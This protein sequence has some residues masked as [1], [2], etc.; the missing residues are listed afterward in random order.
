MA[1]RPERSP[2]AEL[3]DGAHHAPAGPFGPF[4]LDEYPKLVALVTAL[5]GDRGLAEDVAQEAMLRAYRRWATV[6]GYERPGAWVRRV[7][8]NLASSARRRRRAER[9]A[10]A[11]LAARPQIVVPE[12]SAES[13]ELW[14]QVRTL[15]RRQATAVTLYY[16]ADASV[17]DVAAAMG[18][19]EGTAKAHLHQARAALAVRVGDPE[20]EEIR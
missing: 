5:T 12:L 4:F 20:P 7:A 9:R 10:V 1:V 14:A 16:L 13:A 11:R 8:L 2:A 6:S 15:P 19:A 3:S 18:C 17:A